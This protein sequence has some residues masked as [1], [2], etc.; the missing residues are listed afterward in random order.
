MQTA[1]LVFLGG[2]VGSVLRWLTGLA[3]SRLFG[4]GFPL[5]TLAVNLLGCFAMG[6]FARILLS[7]DAGGGHARVLLM[8]GLLG[9]YTTFSAFALDTANLWMRDATG[10]ALIYIGLTMVGSLGAVALGLWLGAGWTR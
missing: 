8:T 7:P 3:A 10:L 2:G 1:F 6:V 5:G 4:T 9:G